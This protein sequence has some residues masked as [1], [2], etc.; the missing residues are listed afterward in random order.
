[1][2][3]EPIDLMLRTVP[4]SGLIQIA[5]NG[6]WQSAFSENTTLAFEPGKTYRLRFVSMSALAMFS[7]HL[8]GHNMTVIEVDGTDIEP[9]P[10]DVVTVSAAQRVSVLVT[11]LNTTDTNYLL[12][13]DMVGHALVF[14]LQTIRTDSILHRRVQT[15]LIPFQTT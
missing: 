7:I 12:H 4:K 5:Q 6:T 13:A 14:L 3:I 15:C 9:Y 8:D 11:A 10:I 1:M 2:L